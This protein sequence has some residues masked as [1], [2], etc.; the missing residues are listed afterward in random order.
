[1]TNIRFE[2]RLFFLEGRDKWLLSE[3]LRWMKCL[4]RVHRL[5]QA[6][7]VTIKTLSS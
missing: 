7:G 1:M 2:K 4:K 3:T 5:D 6:W